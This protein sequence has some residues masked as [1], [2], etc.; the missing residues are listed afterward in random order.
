MDKPL[1]SFII[2]VLNEEAVIAKTIE[3]LKSLVWLNKEIIVADG[4]STDRTVAIAKSL[5]DK[6]YVRPEG[7]KNKSI[8][9]NR[10][11]GAALASG[12]YLFFMDC[13]VQID[14]LDE[15]VKKVISEME[16]KPKNLG[17]TLEIRFY[18]GEESRVDRVHLWMINKTIEGLNK[19]KMGMAM[20]WV[21]VVK[22]EAFEKIGGYNEDLITQEDVDLFRRLSRIG[23]TVSLKNFVAYGSADRYHRDGWLKVNLR[24]LANW[25]SY[26]TRGKSYSKVWKEVGSDG[27]K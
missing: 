26:I 5:A 9:E 11:K 7:E 13:G 19:V 4:G 16:A 18:P 6:V 20:G 27:K 1:I 3:P 17:M 14:K 24:W 10:N 15:F 2:P 21:Q 25:L 23:K 22:K 12:K 8:A